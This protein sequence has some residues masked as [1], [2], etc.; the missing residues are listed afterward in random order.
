MIRHLLGEL[1]Y[2]ANANAVLAWYQE[3]FY[4]L[5]RD[6]LLSF[7][8]RDGFDVQRLTDRCWYEGCG[9]NC[10]KCRA[11]GIYRTR[12][13]A[14]SRWRLGRRNFLTPESAVRDEHL[15]GVLARCRRVIEGRVRHEHVKPWVGHAATLILALCFGYPGLARTA[16][17]ELPRMTAL[18]DWLDERRPF[19][20]SWF[21][22]RMECFECGRWSLTARRANPFCRLCVA[23]ADRAETPP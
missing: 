1:L 14:L 8:V 11:T 21:G 18:V 9:P 3:S 16:F 2:R 20:S 6:I 19:R 10:P 4:Y 17:M 5:K 23:D 15:E 13:W 22:L 12:H 7:G